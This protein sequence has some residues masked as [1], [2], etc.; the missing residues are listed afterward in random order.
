[1]AVSKERKSELVEGYL[2]QL[3]GCEGVV[4]A[5]YR[6]LSV[7][8]M[9]DLRRELRP[10]DARLQVVKNTMLKRAF[11]EAGMSL[12][13][14]WLIGPTAVGFCYGEVAPVAK[15]LKGAESDLGR[16]RIKG[17]LLGTTVTPADQVRAIA[18][19]P[20]R[21]VLLGQVLGTINAP[22]SQ[23]VG[24]LAGGIRQ[25]MNV[26]QAYVEK[27]EESGPAASST[28]EQVPQAA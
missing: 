16:L 15:V 28:P 12:P 20:S 6:G 9:T 11:E 25:I 3:K 2:E 1:M 19:L 26:L 4:L 21:D 23:L 5:D 8:E 10:C 24:V 7:D 22:A 18:D 14:D 27:L 17:G 13:E